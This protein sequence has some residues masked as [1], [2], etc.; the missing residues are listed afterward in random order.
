MTTAE[1]LAELEQ[2]IRN[3]IPRLKELTKGCKFSVLYKGGIGEDGLIV[4]KNEFEAL[5]IVFSNRLE[6]IK[7][8]DFNPTFIIGHDIMLNDVLEWFYESFTEYYYI[9]VDKYGDVIIRNEYTNKETYL[10]WNLS[11]PYLKDQSKELIK[12]LYELIKE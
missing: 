8:D 11:S 12:F 9:Y 4:D 3:D 6:H 7:K 1:M 2:Q 5:K 10:Y